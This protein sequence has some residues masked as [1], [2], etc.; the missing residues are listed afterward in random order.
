MKSLN[1]K[2]LQE[3]QLWQ[4]RMITLLV[5]AMVALIVVVGVD[6]IIGMSR[7]AASFVFLGLVALAGLG[8][9]IQFSQKCPACGYRLGFQTRLLIPNNCKK[10]G[11]GLK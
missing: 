10:C 6:L 3:L 4:K 8:I 2:E 1:T 9:F 5:I 7:M 11:V